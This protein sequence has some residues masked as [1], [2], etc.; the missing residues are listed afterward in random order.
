MR[1]VLI[2]LL[3]ASPALAAK[4]SEVDVEAERA[5]AEAAERAA[6]AEQARAAA[7]EARKQA[8]AD[9]Y[10]REYAWLVAEKRALAERLSAIQAETATLRT[11]AEG[12]IASMQGRLIAQTLKADEAERSLADVEEQTMGKA[13]D[14]DRLIGALEQAE[15]TLGRPATGD[16]TPAQWVGQSFALA[17]DM[18]GKA[19]AVS[20][21]DEAFFATDG[22]KLQGTVV[23]VGTVA[24]FGV[25]GEQAGALVPAGGGKL[26]LHQGPGADVARA[27]AAGSQP[28]QLGMFFVE[29]PDQALVVEQ[30][31]TVA[32]VIEDGGTVGNVIIGLGVLAL[33]M[34][35][36]RGGYL[37]G[38]GSRA[39]GLMG[40]V[41][42]A[43]RGGRLGDLTGKVQGAG[44]VAGTLLNKVL[45]PGLSRADRE[46]VLEESL[47]EAGS[48][49]GRFATPIQ[50]IAAVAPLLGLLGT[51]TGMIATFDVITT[52]GTGD[53]K[54][55]SGGIS[56]ALVT[57]E[58]GLIVAIPCLLVGSLLNARAER[59]LDHIERGA[60]EALRFVS[61]AQSLEGG[62]P[63]TDGAP[64]HG[65]DAAVLNA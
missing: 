50:V 55:L 12:D 34:M 58:L 65:G 10:Q 19:A 52:H 18:L 26:R 29:K 15:T 22:S 20:S 54:M 28:S 23:R 13:D 60:L 42:A 41:E 37:L 51:V 45:D 1:L 38:P 39:V 59:I 17:Q 31:K 44:G 7:A 3:L 32:D 61:A 25:A 11:K 33:L 43:V 4:K 40:G 16:P 53:P 8:L 30:E 2:L 14:L 27:L 35:F 56:A 48:T 36:V 6:E 57:T 5:A 62:R 47:L 63:A 64:S 9:A 49:L 46:E 21:A 24:T